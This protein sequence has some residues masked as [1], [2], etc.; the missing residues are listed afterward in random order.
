MKTF[1]FKHPVL[2]TLIVLFGVVPVAMTAIAKVR[3]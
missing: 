2:A 1:I 3:E